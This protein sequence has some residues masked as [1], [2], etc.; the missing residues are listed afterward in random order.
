M[1]TVAILQARMGSSRLPGKVL[2]RLGERS[3]LLHCLERAK[4]VPGVDAVCLATSVEA[5][6]D[7]VAEEA[8]RVAGVI[9]CRGSEK[10]VLA[11]YAQAARESSADVILRITCDCPLIDPEVCAGVIALQRETGAFYA[12]NNIRREWPH[13]LDCEVFA[14]R[15]LEQADLEATEPFDREHVGPWIKRRAG[16]AAAH[17]PGPGGRAAQ[18][19]W[20]L[21]YPEDLEFL[22]ALWPLLPADRM[23]AWREV[24]DILEAH[25]EI[26]AL[27]RSRAVAS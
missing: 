6:D 25:P 15:A 22:R 21:D 8:R 1:G 11:R 26:A 16:V 5:A 20:T 18:Q 3:V 4:A 24:M 9:V 23:A 12:S 13:G 2:E 10:D 19:R 7:A 17:F 14:R 27:N